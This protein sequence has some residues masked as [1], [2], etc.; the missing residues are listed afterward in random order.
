ME[1]RKDLEVREKRKPNK[2]KKDIGNEKKKN[3]KGKQM[4]RENKIKNEKEE[5]QHL[6]FFQDP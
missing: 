5:T 3:N 6:H 2:H 4:E 1:M